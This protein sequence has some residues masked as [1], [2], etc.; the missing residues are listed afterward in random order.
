MAR[1]MY[2]EFELNKLSG[3]NKILQR[4]PYDN[5]M[6]NYTISRDEG[7]TANEVIFEVLTQAASCGYEY[8]VRGVIINGLIDVNYTSA[9]DGTT[10]LFWAFDNACLEVIKY[11]VE[12]G[13][14]VEDISVDRTSGLIR[15]AEIGDIDILNYFFDQQVDANYRDINGLTALASGIDIRE[16]LV[17]GVEALLNYGCDVDAESDVGMTPLMYACDSDDID[18]VTLEIIECLLQNCAD[19]NKQDLCGYSSLMFAAQYGDIA[20]VKCLLLYGADIDQQNYIGDTP[21]MIAMKNMHVDIVRYLIQHNANTDIVNH[22]GH[23]VGDIAEYVGMNDLMI[24]GEVRQHF[25][26]YDL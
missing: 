5:L 26:M 1:R 4:F 20:I 3:L 17:E 19:V 21:I 18:E 6:E 8:V 13:A 24:G 23:T 2:T 9:D 12:A 11:L 22:C 10:V 7:K 14:K 25:S 15:A 16:I